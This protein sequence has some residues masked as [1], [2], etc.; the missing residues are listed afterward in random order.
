LTEP[1]QTSKAIA[2]AT[3]P[4]LASLVFLRKRLITRTLLVQSAC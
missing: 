1:A 4:A 2:N 3:E